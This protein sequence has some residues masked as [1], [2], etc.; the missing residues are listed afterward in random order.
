MRLTQSY[1]PQATNLDDC[2]DWC[3][4]T[5]AI[6]KHGTK[7][8][9]PALLRVPP[10][11]RTLLHMDRNQCLLR[12]RAIKLFAMPLHVTFHTLLAEN[13]ILLESLLRRLALQGQ[14]ICTAL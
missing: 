8:V 13:V 12:F 2:F 7:P 14:H 9:A 6:K 1:A 3:A 10:G 4:A 5:V 11:K